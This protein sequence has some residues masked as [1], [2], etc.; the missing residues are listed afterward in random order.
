MRKMRKTRK[1]RILCQLGRPVMTSF[2]FG[3]NTYPFKALQVSLMSK[4]VLEIL[5]TL[6]GSCGLL[7]DFQFS[8]QPF[9]RFSEFAIALLCT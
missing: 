8:D 5:R 6:I 2:P 1:I 4:T 7:S 9:D 3:S